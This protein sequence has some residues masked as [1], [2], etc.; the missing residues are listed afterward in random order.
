MK[1]WILAGVI[2]ALPLTGAPVLAA[3]VDDY[4]ALREE[5]WQW[6]LD[7]S[8]LTAMRVG[9]RRGD[10]KIGDL[11]EAAEQRQ[12]AE[13]RAFRKRFAAID[14]GA[15][16]ND[17]RVDYGVLLRGIDDQLA[18][19]EFPH[20]R[21]MI[22]T[23]R[24]GWHM[25]FAGLPE[26]SPFFTKADYD[27][28]IG[29][30]E[31]YSEQNAAGIAR[32]RKAIAGGLMQPCEPMETFI[33]TIEGRY[34][35]TAESSS[36]WMPFSERP[37]TISEGEWEDLKTRARAA[38]EQ[39]V[40]PAYR[41]FGE[42]YTAEYEPKCRDTIGISET[43]GGT[44]YYQ[45]LIKSFTTTDM[46]ADEVHKLGLSEV[47]R[48]RAEMETVAA[49]AG[50]AGDRKGFIEDLRTNPV[51]YPKTGDELLQVT[52]AQT[53]LIDGWMP[54]L[55]GTLPR[56]PYTVK[57]IPMDQ[58]VGN[59]TAYYEL[60]SLAIGRPGIYRV[61]LTALDQRPLWEVPVLSIHEAVPGHHH[62]L[63]L[64]QEL[65]MHPIRQFGSNFTAFVEGWGLY[66]EQLGK[67][68]GMYDTPAKKMGQLSYEMWRACRLVVD[69][70]IHSKGW[71]KARAVA[72]MTDNSAL[73][74]ANID[75]EVNRYITWPGQALAYK[76][77][78]LKIRALR[79]R[80][81]TALGPSFNLRTFHD[82]VLENGAVPLD[83][84]EGHVDRWIAAE[85]A[86][87]IEEGVS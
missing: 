66:S 7:N 37:D 44:D 84:L 30:L 69:T 17:L 33:G 23:N 35:D 12:L 43:P 50:F 26:G 68:M 38:I 24:G 36:F 8:P 79:E 53:K 64:Q 25:W 80:A 57:P 77:G 52:A 73:S 4:T 47:A 76:V 45:Y 28:Y 67:E 6:T 15:L 72:F 87:V 3:P 74:A 54:Q 46:T 49:E 19:A 16:P 61:N 29:R 63:S 32:T 9:D 14:V 81:E 71:S 59:T 75:A 83:V 60:G 18:G 22:F 2:A 11:S 51:Y 42:F 86:K 78:E 48:I 56:L 20:S 21:Y 65:E 13:V 82:A 70:G 55:F 31:N 39:S 85:Q 58:A 40:I 1:N 10:S 62:Q 5:L 27:S 34:A 41:Q